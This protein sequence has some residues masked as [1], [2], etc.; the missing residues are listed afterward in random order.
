M[1]YLLNMLAFLFAGICT[2]Q[3]QESCYVNQAYVDTYLYT[4]EDF[5]QSF[6]PCTTAELYRIDL[7]IHNLQEGEFEATLTIYEGDGYTGNV[8]YSQSVTIGDEWGSYL[9]HT[10]TTPLWMQDGVTYTYRLDFNGHYGTMWANF[11]NI[12][13]DGQNYWNGTAQPSIDMGFMLHMYLIEDPCAAWLGSVSESWDEPLNWDPAIV[14]DSLD[15]VL[16]SGGAPFDP[17]IPVKADVKD[18]TVLPEG[19][20]TLLTD[21]ELSVFHT[22]DVQGES[23]FDGTVFMKQG[24]T[25]GEI[26]GSPIFNILKLEGFYVLTEPV[27]VLDLLDVEF[28]YL[29]NIGTQL[30]LKVNSEHSGHVY[31]PTENIAG[32]VTFEKQAPIMDGEMVGIPFNDLSSQTLA[33]Q[34]SS[35]SITAYNTLAPLLDCENLWSHVLENDSLFSNADVVMVESAEELIHVTGQ[36][37]NATVHVVHVNGGVDNYDLRPVGNP[38]P[39]VISAAAIARS[40]G[41]PKVTY[42][43]N[44]S[45]RQYNALVDNAEVHPMTRHMKPL[46]AVLIHIPEGEEVT[47]DYSVAALRPYELNSPEELEDLSDHHIRLHIES[48]SG[49]DE[50][51]LRF[52]TGA[53]WVWDPAMDAMKIA[54]M[55]DLMPTLGTMGQGAKVLAI[56]SIPMLVHGQ[57][58]AL[59]LSPGVEGPVQISAPMIDGGDCFTTLHLEDRKLGYFHDFMTNGVYST[60]VLLT[61]D[62]NRFILHFDRNQQNNTPSEVDEAFNVDPVTPIG[63]IEIDNPS[64]E[65]ELTDYTIGVYSGELTIR[66]GDGLMEIPQETMITVYSVNGKLVFQRKLMQSSSKFTYQLNVS[67]GIYHVE[68]I[69]EGKRQREKVWVD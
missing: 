29:A 21:A 60:E 18:L 49:E 43:W 31:M 39:S 9:I 46:D 58:V 55:D 30:T 16:I 51:L 17:I 22:L 14:P 34:N 44:P 3:A 57:Q 13:P 37:S 48:P 23:E 8:L 12:Y 65:E 69:T 68:L 4:Q 47:I 45:E 41:I 27:T 40:S 56:N 11:A 6:L 35:A 38:F 64:F 53:S 36:T 5:G 1:K 66:P 33:S 59:Y 7:P 25:G 10:L 54:S 50:T 28:G 61:D 42:R 63:P 2:S 67:P 26:L 62:K 52:K 32:A 15:C 24:V 19:H 20:L